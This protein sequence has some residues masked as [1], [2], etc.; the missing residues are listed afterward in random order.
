MAASSVDRF[1]PGTERDCSVATKEII[2]RLLD[3]FENTSK[4]EVHVYVPLSL[5]SVTNYKL[6]PL[7]LAYIAN[8]FNF[9]C[10]LTKKF[11]KEQFPCLPPYC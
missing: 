8:L 6:Y 10:F 4:Y 11:V 3:D 2:L 7:E 9:P 1:I 5:F